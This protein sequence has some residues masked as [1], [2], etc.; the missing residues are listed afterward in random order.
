MI[1]FMADT[2]QEAVFRPIAM[3]APSTWVYSEIMAPDFRFVSALVLAVA[4]LILALYRSDAAVSAGQRPTF[5]LLFLVFISFIPWMSTTGNG[6]YFM[7]YLLLIG[8]LCIGLVNI[9]SITRNMKASLVL[10]I[11]GIQ[12]FAFF[13]NNPWIAADSWQSV[14]WKDSPYFLVETEEKALDKDSLYISVGNNSFS[15]VA[16]LFSPSSQWVNLSIFSGIDV[17]KNVPIYEP[18]RRRLLTARSLKLFQRS[19]PRE[20][21]AG[22]NQPNSNA[23]A[24]INA[25]LRP[26]LLALKEPTDCILLP[27]KTLGNHTHT[28]ADDS[29]T[30]KE[31]FVNNA[32]FW[33]CSLTYPI[34]FNEDE[35]ADPARIVAKNALERMESLCPRNFPPGQQLVGPHPAGFTR[36]YPSSDSALIITRDGHIYFKYS[37]ALNPQLIAMVDDIQLPEYKF[38]CNKFKGRGG[39][40]WDREI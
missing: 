21:L 27:S 33:I 37:R 10:L 23:I 36:A 1:R 9:L 38:D 19:A 16:P 24:A 39:L 31:R 14:A 6:R 29:R 35:S 12:G 28:L 17:K 7:P 20:M 15:L 2:W 18:V 34:T 40:P 26:H 5:A 8:P 3:A 32:G 13:Q 11:L 30:E 25:Y 4:T 22:T